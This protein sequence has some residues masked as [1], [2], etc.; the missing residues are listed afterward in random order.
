VPRDADPDATRA[1]PSPAEAPTVDAASADADAP[2]SFDDLLR[3]VVGG[4]ATGDLPAG[5]K[6]GGGRFTIT[7]VLGEG[8]M[9]TVY[10]ARDASLG[11]DVAIKVHHSAGGADRLRREAVAMARLA[12][13]HVVAVFEVGDLDGRPFVVMEYVP[14]TTLR[15]WLAAAP[16][17]VADILAMVI[18]AGEGLAAAHAAG[19]VHRDFKPENVLIGDDGRARVGD[20]GLAR[21]LTSA[22]QRAAPA[23]PSGDAADNLR[24]PVTQT[25]AVL[26]TPAYM[27]PEQFAGEPVDA[28]ADQF[29]FCVTAWEALWGERPF[30]GAS[31]AQLHASIATGARRA[32][33]AIP[34]VAAR[35][36][37]ALERGLATDPAARFPSMRALIAALR[38]PRR[39]R[40]WIVAL[41]GAAIAAAATW[42]ALRERPG[43]SC[44]DAGAAALA[45]VRDQLTRLRVA[46]GTAAAATVDAWIAQFQRGAQLACQADRAHDWAPAIAARSQVCLAVLARTAAL[47]LAGADPRQPADLIRRIERLPP[48]DPCRNPTHLAARPA[49]PA[50]PYRLAAL[51]EANA[52]LAVGFDAVDHHDYPAL[53]RAADQLA[54]SPAHADPGIAAGVLVLRG[55]LAYEHGDLARARALFTD[56][57]YAGRAIDDDQVTCVALGLL[58]GQGPDL[59]L[60]PDEIAGWLRTA[61]ADADRIRARAPWLAGRV[62]SVAAQAADT[63]NDAAGAALFIARA[64]EVLV[65][66]DPARIETYTVE[67][68]VLF[69]SGRIDDGV[70][71]Y[72]SAIAQT[73][74]RFG[75]DTP[76]VA[77]VLSN[78]AASLLDA[79]QLTE[80][81][82]RADRA[83]QIVS[84]LADPD[85]ERIDRVR[86][87]LAAVLIAANQDAEA[88]DLLEAARAHAVRRGGAATPAVANIDTNL[89]TIYTARGY[90][91]RAI[92]ALEAAR[93]TDVHLLGPDHLELATVH[94]NLAVARRA[95]HDLPGAR[96]DA[97]RAVEIYARTAPGTDRHH[98]ALVMTAS[99][100]SEAHDFAAAL[101][102][103]DPLAAPAAGDAPQTTA[104]AQLE[105]A[106]A[107]DGLGRPAEARPLL[108]AARAGFAALHMTP[109]VAQIDALL[110]RH[111]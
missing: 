88:A 102:A 97:R 62:Y 108:A 92:A 110:A 29:A 11:R 49:I 65:A 14:G 74:A 42:A 52:T 4:A 12:H 66:T 84:K 93:A 17:A 43:P 24:T 103:T 25:G 57:Y 71:A 16:R 22:E 89:A 26:G 35:I 86:V 111:R 67:G 69:W 81:M 58:I 90:H 79:A 36:R 68:G 2:D 73:I 20:F 85:D 64:R 50:E 6:L 46:P 7:R 55:H 28:R 83:L 104:W 33:P 63:A 53:R 98:V 76:E 95:A 13:P 109:R 41:T 38:P 37:A 44:D 21:E 9:G 3:K 56:G 15:A 48:D 40:R 96:A 34:K 1:Q 72:E 30:A 105:R 75:D 54:A 101:A 5:S 70:R 59:G 106:I 31:F 32:P 61:L 8:G 94:Y 51:I 45:A 100:A 23:P 47:E 10:V 99:L 27:A 107:L 82:Q 19:L 77:Q 39:R 80:A 60:T 18:A 87:N 78:Y 91:A